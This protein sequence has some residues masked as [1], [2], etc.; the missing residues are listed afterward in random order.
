VAKVGFEIELIVWSGHCC[1]LP[2]TL[3]LR[4]GYAG[5]GAIEEQGTL[6]CV[7]G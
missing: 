5:L 7:L 2:L 4:A 6:S 3:R 1:P